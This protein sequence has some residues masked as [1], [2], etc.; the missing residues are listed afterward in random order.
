MSNNLMKRSVNRSKKVRDFSPFS[1]VKFL[2]E[3]SNIN[4]N[5]ITSLPN[6][7]TDKLF[8]KFYN[9]LNKVVNTHVPFK[10]VSKRRV[11]Q[12]SKP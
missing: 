1:E 6:M 4:W 9:K 12:L 8:S 7:N 10:A 5:E 3:V 11:R 2:A